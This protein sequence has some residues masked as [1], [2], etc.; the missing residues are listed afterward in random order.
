MRALTR[1]SKVFNS[2][3]TNN[4]NMKKEGV[5]LGLYSILAILK[6]TQDVH[7]KSLYKTQIAKLLYLIHKLKRINVGY[8][9]QDDNFGP[10]DRQIDIDLKFGK[11]IGLIDENIIDKEYVN[12][13]IKY[14]YIITIDGEKQLKEYSKELSS[15]KF[16]ESIKEICKKYGGLSTRE[17]LDFVYAQHYKKYSDLKEDIQRLQNNLKKIYVILDCQY[18]LNL[19]ERT[20]QILIKIEYCNYL[21]NKL[22]KISSQTEQNIIVQEIKF[23]IDDISSS[24]NN[25]EEITCEDE[26]NDIFVHLNDT[27]KS[28]GLPT[29]DDKNIEFTEFLD[30]EE[31]KCLMKNTVEI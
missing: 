26:L 9:F 22:S 30:E 12:L 13:C 27:A 17:L 14:N 16:I 6:C 31:I 4:T 19:S 21:L 25:I 28:N 29:Y 1:K 24:I 15:K 10:Y 8:S 18:K 11:N 23:F 20:D 5:D 3:S 7:N 2:K